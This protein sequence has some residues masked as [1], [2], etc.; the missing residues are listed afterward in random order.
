MFTRAVQKKALAAGAASP[1]QFIWLCTLALLATALLGACSGSNQK[2]E[3]TAQSNTMP[4]DTTPQST[5]TPAQNRPVILC[6]GNSI[7]AGYGVAPEEA[8]PNL[9]QQKADSLGYAYEVI[10]AGVS[11]E[12]SQGGLSR[13]NWV[14]GRQNNLAVFI[15]ELGAN[16]GLRGL[17]LNQTKQNLGAIIEAVRAKAPQA[18]IVLAGMEIPPNMG[19]EYT[20]QFRELFKTLA[21]EYNTELIPFILQGVAGEPSLNLEDG[22]HPTP[23]G[24][25]IV[26]QTV[27]Q[28]LA[29]L[30]SK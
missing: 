19:Q 24:H 20:A 6:Y 3:P 25:T 23:Q 18:T 15:L 13:L 29:P 8:W 27:W 1:V 26:A 22:I 14:L 12:T 30:L 4:A 7:T 11:G 5:N 21:Q 2:Q 10:N 9:T 28:S 17:S 16:D